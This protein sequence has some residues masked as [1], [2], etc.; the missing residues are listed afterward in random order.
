[1]RLQWRSKN[2]TEARLVSQQLQRQGKLKTVHQLNSIATG[3][4]VGIVELCDYARA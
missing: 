4:S 3:P 1:M 2:S